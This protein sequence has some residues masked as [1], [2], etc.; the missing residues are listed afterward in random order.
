ME[1]SQS[2]QTSGIALTWVLVILCVV[3]VAAFVGGFAASNAIAST[4]KSDAW[5]S[6]EKAWDV[7][8][9]EFYYPKP[10]NG[11]RMRGAI[12][13]MLATLKDKYTLLIPPKDAEADAVV[14]NGDSGGIGAKI[15]T[16][17]DG[18]IVIAEAL[19]GKPAAE[20]GLQSGDI[21]IA[22]DGVPLKGLTVQEAIQK[23]RGPIGSPVKLTI[24]RGDLQHDYTVTRQQ[25][26]VIS[27]MLAG[28]IGYVSL[29]LF[30]EKSAVRL[31]EAI[32]PLLDKGAK[33]LVF[34]LRD[35]PGGYLDQAIA[36]A[37]LFLPG[38]V[39][40]HEK[41]TSGENK[42]FNSKDGDLAE[43]IPLYVLVNQNSASAAEI[44]SGALKDR[45]RARLI[46]QT[47]YGK[48]SVQSL[49]KLDDGSQLR[50]TS[51]AWYTPK[52]TPIQGVGL[53][54]DDW[55]TTPDVFAPGTD[56]VLDST[57]AYI[58]G[59]RPDTF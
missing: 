57:I 43:G 14:M 30:D 38:G 3:A 55:V 46:G 5:S 59:N 7:V 32:K 4:P 53:P 11:T 26:N 52:D 2:Q 27:K 41:A 20:A 47:T 35:N 13:G 42:T 18:Q 23:V 17:A 1:D 28:N 25:I 15:T 50:V 8:N 12:A 6:F 36:V 16:N 54:V 37:D 40:A 44:V 56:P 49:F 34:D 19:V 31:Q 51:G 24:Q 9:T 58:Q 29:A 10:D 45:G 39:V 22:A 33:A 48:G 21:L